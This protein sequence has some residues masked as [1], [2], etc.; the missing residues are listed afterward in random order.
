MTELLLVV[1]F[2]VL[3]QPDKTWKVGDETLLTRVKANPQDYL[4]KVFIICGGV[5]V[6][7]YYIWAPYD[8]RAKDTH[9][10]LEFREAAKD[11][12]SFSGE[13]AHLYLSKQRGKPIMDALMKVAEDTVGPNL[14]KTVRVK[15]TLRP[16]VYARDKHWDLL[17]VLDVQFG[18]REKKQ[19][20][21][22]ATEQAEKDRIK[23]FKE[24][25]R[26]AEQEA[27]QKAQDQAEQKKAIRAAKR[28]TWKSGTHSVEAELIK[29]V[30]GIVHLQRLDNGQQITIPMEKL[31][32]EDQEFI[33]GRKWESAVPK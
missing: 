13:S 19:W 17:E 16:E 12:E 4:G 7:D 27:E 11:M 29:V 5:Q 2:I 25:Q 8:D 24:A 30:R 6:D 23:N 31:S 20:G 32:K 22:W 18:D 3:S 21:P 33:T 14:Y 9:Y 1:P 26:R 28:R 10:S 15:V